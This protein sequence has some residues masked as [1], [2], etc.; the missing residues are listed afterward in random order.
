MKGGS[1]PRS[2]AGKWFG[3]QELDEERSYEGFRGLREPDS[4]GVRQ[5]LGAWGGRVCRP[6][7]EPGWAVK[8]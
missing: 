2:L 3:E 8:R 7:A 6:C 1:A 4:G 5:G